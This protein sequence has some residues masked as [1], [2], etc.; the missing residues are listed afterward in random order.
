MIDWFDLPAVQGTLKMWPSPAPQFES[1][2]FSA[3]NLLYGATLTFIHDYWK[4]H[5]F[6]YMDLCRQS[7]VSA[8]Q[9]TLQVCHNIFS[10]EQE[11]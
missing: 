7:D 2:S 3:L 8:F 10:K 11:S 1:I 6:D 5:S 4:N 9:Y